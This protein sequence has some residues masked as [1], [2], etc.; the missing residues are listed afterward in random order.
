MRVLSMAFMVLMSCGPHTE[1]VAPS[2]VGAQMIS[3]CRT[4]DTQ[5]WC[6]TTCVSVVANGTG[7]MNAEGRFVSAACVCSDPAN[8]REALLDVEA[9]LCIDL[10]DEFIAMSGYQGPP[11]PINPKISYQDAVVYFTALLGA[12]EAVEL[13]NALNTDG[14]GWLTRTEASLAKGADPNQTLTTS[15]SSG[16]AMDDVLAYIGL[17]LG[18][19]AVDKYAGDL[20]DEVL[21][22]MLTFTRSW[23]PG[24]YNSA[25]VPTT[26]A[27]GPGKP[28]PGPLRRATTLQRPKGMATARLRVQD[29]TRLPAKSDASSTLHKLQ[30]RHAART[31]PTRTRVAMRAT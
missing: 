17:Y 4:A 3:G 9:N 15:L 14:D 1:P 6:D 11:P 12:Q 5:D 20:D 24:Q 28:P 29:R 26:P 27:C 7:C 25:Y 23:Q 30:L 21:D 2:P 16:L 22:A 13:A 19:G 8:T 31:S 18:D 10:D